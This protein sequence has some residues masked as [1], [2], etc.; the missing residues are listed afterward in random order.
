MVLDLEYGVNP[1]CKGLERLSV[2]YVAAEDYPIC[3]PVKLVRDVPELL[4]T[5]SVPDLDRNFCSITRVY[6][7]SLNVVY[8]DRLQV[9]CLEVS[10]VHIPQ[11]ARLA[12]GRITQNYQV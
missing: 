6:P 7:I 2:G 12:N 9:L 4:L 8:R 11:Q 3:L 10:I 5:C 1:A